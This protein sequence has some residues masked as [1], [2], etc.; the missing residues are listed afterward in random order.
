MHFSHGVR[1]T[2]AG[3]EFSGGSRISQMREGSANFQG[4]GANLLFGQISP[5]N[6]MKMKEF[7]PG[8]DGACLWCLP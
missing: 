4:G 7:G 2:V 3:A 6:C 1:S 5:E 8:G